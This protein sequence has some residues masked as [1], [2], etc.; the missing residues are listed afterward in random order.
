MS[1][2]VGNLIVSL[3]ELGGVLGS[4]GQLEKVEKNSKN[5]SSRGANEYNEAVLSKILFDLPLQVWQFF[6]VYKTMYQF[7]H[8]I[9][10]CG[11]L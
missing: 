4:S 1:S 6:S 7:L 10:R 5:N 11:T 8:F 9:F 2:S 3:K